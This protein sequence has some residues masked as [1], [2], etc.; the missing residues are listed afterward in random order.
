M[1]GKASSKNNKEDIRLLCNKLTLTAET[2]EE[3]R[4]LAVIYMSLFHSK[5]SEKL[6]QLFEEVSKEL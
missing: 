3:R 6:N 1:K 5:H 2:K 4:L